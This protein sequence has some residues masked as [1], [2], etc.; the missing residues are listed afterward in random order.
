[1]ALALG[2]RAQGSSG[3]RLTHRQASAALPIAERSGEP[4]RYRDVALPAAVARDDLLASSLARLYLDPLEAG[5]DGGEALRQTLRAYFEAERN[6]SSAAVALGVSRT[7]VTSR[8][9]LAEELLD[10]PLS[11]CAAELDVALRFEA[12]GELAGS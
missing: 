7:T 1:V 9:R 6:I 8:L 10:R 5:R 12:L 3:W 11:A 2:E 4:A